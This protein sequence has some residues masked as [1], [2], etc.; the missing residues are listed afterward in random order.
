MKTKV[1]KGIAHL[2]LISC[3]E[4]E[5]SKNENPKKVGESCGGRKAKGKWMRVGV[6]EKPKES[7]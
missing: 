1:T 4:F 3:L 7:E 6:G 5:S 2:A